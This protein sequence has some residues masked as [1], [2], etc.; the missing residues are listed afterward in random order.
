M[1]WE[2]QA[3]WNDWNF[4]EQDGTKQEVKLAEVGLWRVLSARLYEV[5]HCFIM[6]VCR[7]KKLRPGEA[8]LMVQSHT[9]ST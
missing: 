9:T 5:G 3:V 1:F 7:M 8:K 2:L 6:P 4:I